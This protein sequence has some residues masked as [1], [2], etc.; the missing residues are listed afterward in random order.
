MKTSSTVLITGATG[1][2]GYALAELFA[3]DGYTLVLTGRNEE[4][5]QSIK[6]LWEAKYGVVITYLAQDLAIPPAPEDIYRA[7]QTQKIDVDILINNAG[8]GLL[9][10]FSSLSLPEQLGMI[11][12]N[13]AAL[14]HLTCLFLPGMLQRKQGKIL[15]VASTAAFL[16]GPGM[17]VYYATKA[18][19]LSFSSALSYELR[20]SGVTV[21]ALCPGPTDTGFQSRSGMD[22][23]NLFKRMSVMTAEDVAKIGYRA[24]MKG[25]PVAV[26]GALNTI[27]AIA[28]RFAPRTVLMNLVTSLHHE[29]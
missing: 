17:A 22:N 29:K 5:L 24:L 7:V 15:N 23:T 9:G 6:K 13:V 3:R 14:T 19:V 2:I 4:T 26:A 10:K 12:L 21:T 18:Y 20:S 25:K 1:G 28:A 16:P 11:Q 8:F 27:S